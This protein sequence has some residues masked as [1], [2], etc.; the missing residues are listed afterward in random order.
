MDMNAVRISA[1]WWIGAVTGSKAEDQRAG[2]RADGSA[3]ET[4]ASR[5]RPCHKPLSETPMTWGQATGPV[6]ERHLAQARSGVADPALA[7]RDASGRE[8]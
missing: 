6:R 2:R 3:G 5:H 8:R 1:P 4:G 7:S